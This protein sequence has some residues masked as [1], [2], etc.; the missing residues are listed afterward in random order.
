MSLP[1]APC[2]RHRMS[3]K[4]AARG[5]KVSFTRSSITMGARVN[6]CA[7][8]RTSQTPTPQREEARWR[9]GGPILRLLKAL[10]S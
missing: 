6:T 8:Y 4:K 9:A 3:R 7:T 2:D 5:S 10:C 1:S